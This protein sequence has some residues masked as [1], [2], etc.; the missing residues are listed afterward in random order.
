[1][2]PLSRKYHQVRTQLGLKV[3]PYNEIH[4]L[5]VLVTTVLPVMAS[6]NS[7]SSDYSVPVTTVL[8]VMA[9]DYS[10]TSD[11]SASSDGQCLQ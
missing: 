5:G 2:A 4:C 3:Y 11:Y 10:V 9:S 6:D 1:M 8:P 7:A